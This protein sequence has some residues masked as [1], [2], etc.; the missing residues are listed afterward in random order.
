MS[1]R[2]LI[3]TSTLN[4]L[5]MRREKRFALLIIV[6]L[7]SISTNTYSYVEEWQEI[8]NLILITNGGG[9]KAAYCSYIAQ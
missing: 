5:I 7:I 3:S 4:Y 8:G 1:S 2:T 9:E 6:G